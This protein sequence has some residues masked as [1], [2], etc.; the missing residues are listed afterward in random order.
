MMASVTAIALVACKGKEASPT[1]EGPTQREVELKGAPVLI[2]VGDIAV[3]GSSGDESTGRLADSLVRSDSARGVQTLIITL[4]DNAYPSGDEGVNNDF[5]RCFKPSW[6]GERIMSIIHPS[7]G[8]HDFDSGSGAPYFDFFGQRAGPRDKGYYSFDVNGWHLMSLNSELYFDAGNPVA[9]KAQEDWL[10]GDLQAHPTQCAIAYFHRPYFS[11]GEYGTTRE[12]KT[13]WQILYD[14]GVDLVLNGHEHDYERFL[15]Q[16]ASGVSDS[17]RGMEEIVAGTGGGTLRTFNRPAA[18]SETR[19]QGRFGVLKVW[20][21]N[22]EYTRAFLTADG[23]V[24][25]AGG[26]RCR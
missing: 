22:G 9:A 13:I 2:A 11:S 17:T 15:P 12:L 19:I 14:G 25:D 6:G 4:G 3:C 21:G 20:L 18:N 10:R 1:P 26:R 7:P 16:T 24:W 23:R 5:Q 8:N